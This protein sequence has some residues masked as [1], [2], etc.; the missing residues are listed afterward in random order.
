MAP[1]IREDEGRRWF[2]VWGVKREM[3]SL[4]TPLD[5]LVGRDVEV[6]FQGELYKGVLSGLYAVQGVA[7]LVLVGAGAAEHHIPVAGAV[8]TSQPDPGR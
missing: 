1:A 6:R 8:V 5:K 4:Y 3:L 2:G 7:L